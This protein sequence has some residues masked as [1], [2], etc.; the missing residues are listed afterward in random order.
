MVESTRQ[1]NYTLEQLRGL[2][3]NRKDKWFTQDPRGRYTADE[4]LRSM[5]ICKQLNLFDDW[6]IKVGVDVIMCRNVLIYFKPDYQ[7]KLIG[8]FAAVQNSGG[9]LFLGHSETLS[10][11]KDKYKRVDNTVYERM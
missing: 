10:G 9:F 5:L 8:K 2:S 4:E 7:K 1:G 11:F 6:P 3:A